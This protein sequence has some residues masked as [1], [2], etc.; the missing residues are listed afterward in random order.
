MIAEL[1]PEAYDIEGRPTFRPDQ[2]RRDR[3]PAT[4][5]IGRYIS[6]PLTVKCNTLED[7]RKFLKTCRV[8]SDKD[9]FGKDD[10]WMP[11]EDFE[12][13]RKGDCDDFA[14]YAWRQLMEMGYRARFVGGRIGD[15]PVGHAWVTFELNGK[16]FLLEP[17]RRSL[18]LKL[19]RLDAM[20]YRPYVSVK[21]TGSAPRFFAHAEKKFTPS[22]HI[23]SWLVLEWVW[24]HAR[25]LG[26]RFYL[27]PKA[28]I[29]LIWRKIMPARK[30]TTTARTPSAN[31]PR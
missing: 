2:K 26:L 18:G 10:Y 1:F 25:L 5:P 19:P 30:P 22:F 3:F 31:N 12:K 8:M 7:L 20:Q 9:Q 16:H 21:W 6:Q 24:Y 14:M 13:S 27:V 28:L 17:Q 4:F 29:K 15:S 23:L 11:P